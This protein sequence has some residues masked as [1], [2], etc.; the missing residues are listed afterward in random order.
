MSIS[1]SKNFK[2]CATCDYWLGARD[3]DYFATTVKVESNTEK[4]RCMCPS[5][6]FRNVQRPANMSCA[7]YKKW[8]IFK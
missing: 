7:N 6:G 5:G 4:G 3:I 8:D 2:N 1:Y